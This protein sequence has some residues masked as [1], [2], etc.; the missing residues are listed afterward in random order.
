MTALLPLLSARRDAVMAAL[1]AIA[2]VMLAAPML[3]TRLHEAGVPPLLAALLTM[4]V[5]AGLA[6]N[7]AGYGLAWITNATPR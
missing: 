3:L 6:V 4:A 1:P 5:L 2:L 7:V